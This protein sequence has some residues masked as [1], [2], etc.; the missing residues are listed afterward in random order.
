MLIDVT[1]YRKEKEGGLVGGNQELTMEI[2]RPHREQDRQRTM[3]KQKST[4]V[5]HV[6]HT[7]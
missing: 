4:T 6:L 1:E 7:W 3:T 5:A 2:Q